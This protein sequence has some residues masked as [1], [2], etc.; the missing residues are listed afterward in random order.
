VAD[1]AVLCASAASNYV[2]GH[3][4]E[5]DGRPDAPGSRRQRL[6]ESQSAVH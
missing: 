1:A 2:N 4:L 3:V 6:V 5:I